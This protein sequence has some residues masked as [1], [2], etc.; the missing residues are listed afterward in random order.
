MSLG[1]RECG[2]AGCFEIPSTCNRPDEKKLTSDGVQMNPYGNIMMSRRVAKALGATNVQL[3]ESEKA[4]R[5]ASS[6]SVRLGDIKLSIDAIETLNTAAKAE[7]TDIR[8]L[9][10]KAAEARKGDVINAVDKTGT[11]TVLCR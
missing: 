10:R 1:R 5:S 8:G 11:A 2:Y 7:G 9:L 3:D 6:Y 4:W